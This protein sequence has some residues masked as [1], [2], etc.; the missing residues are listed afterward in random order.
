M[1]D[2]TIRAESTDSPK[3][4]AGKERSPAVQEV[5]AFSLKVPWLCLSSEAGEDADS[6]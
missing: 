1:V 2:K 4:D 5:Q 6:R 3:D